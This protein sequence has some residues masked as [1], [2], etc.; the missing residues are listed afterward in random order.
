[1]TTTR[2]FIRSV[3]VKRAAELKLY[4]ERRKIYLAAHPVDAVWCRERHIMW[5]APCSYQDCKPL[6]SGTVPGSHLI[7]LGAPRATEVHHMNKRRG[8]MLLDENYWMAVSQANHE[9]IE[10]HKAWARREGYLLNF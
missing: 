1:M 7:G 5:L 6:T 8:K 9:R 4:A 2:K 3:S 10:Q